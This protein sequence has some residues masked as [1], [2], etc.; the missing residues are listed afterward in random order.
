MCGLVWG[1]S[2]LNLKEL[3]IVMSNTGTFRKYILGVTKTAKQLCGWVL[4]TFKTKK[5]RVHL[6]ALWKSLLRFKLEYCCQLWCPSQIDDIQAITQ[7]QRNN[8]RTISGIQHLSYRKQL[9]A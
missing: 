9:L 1:Y 7:I 5:K 4:R 8:V 6:L 3:G 2:L